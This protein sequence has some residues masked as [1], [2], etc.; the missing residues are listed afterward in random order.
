M[1]LDIAIVG[2][3]V[4]GLSAAIALARDGH[5][6]TVYESAPELSEVSHIERRG[7]T[8]PQLASGV[9]VDA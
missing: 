4:G 9:T 3:G 6:V 5:H 7:E 2:A 8:L 1:T